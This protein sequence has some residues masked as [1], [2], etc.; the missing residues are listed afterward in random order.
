MRESA[1]RARRPQTEALPTERQ[2]RM[3][4]SHPPAPAET[5]YM[6]ANAPTLSLLEKGPSVRRLAPYPRYMIARD[7]VGVLTDIRRAKALQR[8]SASDPKR[9]F[10]RIKQADGSRSGLSEG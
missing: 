10:H 2:T 4:A 1:R 5:T 7:P 8:V 6:A 9:T 3:H